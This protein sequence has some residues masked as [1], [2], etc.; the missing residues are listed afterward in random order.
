[1]SSANVVDSPEA[2]IRQ[3]TAKLVDT[4]HEIDVDD[5]LD[6]LALAVASAGFPNQR[7]SLPSD[8]PDDAA[9]LPMQIV[10]RPDQPFDGT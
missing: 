9:S 4:P 6:A 1:M 8:P 10:Y 3:I 2:L 5:V 7:Q